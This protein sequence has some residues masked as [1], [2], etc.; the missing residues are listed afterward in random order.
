MLHLRYLCMTI[1]CKEFKNH[2]IPEKNNNYEYKSSISI[3]T[4]QSNNVLLQLKKKLK[5]YSLPLLTNLEILY[6]LFILQSS[7]AKGKNTQC[8]GVIVPKERGAV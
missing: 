1:S 6:K 3:K 2:N 5:V 8:S 7:V 4:S